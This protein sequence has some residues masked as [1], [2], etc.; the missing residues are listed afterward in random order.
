MTESDVSVLFYIA[1]FFWWISA[2]VAV[3]GAAEKRGYGQGTWF[4]LS[5]FLSPIF[6]AILLNAYPVKVISEEVES[7]DGLSITPPTPL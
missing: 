1:I 7:G 5:F 6:T 3:S 4:L 2:S